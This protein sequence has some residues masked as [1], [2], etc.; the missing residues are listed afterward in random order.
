MVSVPSHC[1]GAQRRGD[2][3]ADERAGRGEGGDGDG[4]CKG[5]AGYATTSQKHPSPSILTKPH[6]TDF[7]GE[8][9]FESAFH[10]A[11]PGY[12]NRVSEDRA[13]KEAAEKE[14]AEEKPEPP[15]PVE[16]PTPPPA[17]AVEPAPE[18]APEA[19]PLPTVHT[20]EEG[21]TKMVLGGASEMGLTDAF[22]LFA[23][24]RVAEGAGYEERANND[25]GVFGCGAPDGASSYFALTL[26]ELKPFVAFHA[27][28]ESVATEEP[29]TEDEWTHLALTFDP[30]SKEAVLFINGTEKARGPLEGGIPEATC[31]AVLGSTPY[32][33]ESNTQFLGKVCFSKRVA[34]SVRL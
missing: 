31:E 24:L 15:P 26:R 10:K 23:W 3:V 30:A 7:V 14:A 8:E 19:A 33:A 2:E 1:T 5:A 9:K 27:G 22:T 34:N 16:E 20:F 4:S 32:A 12:E 17:E 28:G 18:K 21:S 6:T 29:I 13:Q 11:L 25:L